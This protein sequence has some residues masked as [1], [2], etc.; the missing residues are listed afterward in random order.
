MRMTHRTSCLAIVF[1]LSVPAFGQPDTCCCYA[2]TS[3]DT[4]CPACTF[5]YCA[6]SNGVCPQYNVICNG[7][8]TPVEVEFGMTLAYFETHCAWSAQCVQPLTPPCNPIVNEC[9]RV[10]ELKIGTMSVPYSWLPCP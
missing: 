3:T 8:K 4:F 6:C 9:V 5:S 2:M 10:N 7:H 1:S